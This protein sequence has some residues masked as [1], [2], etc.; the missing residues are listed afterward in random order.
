MHKHINQKL[1]N[2][3]LEFEFAFDKLNNVIWEVYK[4]TLKISV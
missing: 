3:T 1:I 4:Y 2:Y